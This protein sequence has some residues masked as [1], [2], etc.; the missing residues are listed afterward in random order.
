VKQFGL[1][2]MAD[3]SVNH[4]APDPGAVLAALGLV[5]PSRIT[6]VSGGADATIWRVGYGDADYALRLLRADQAAMARREA[7]AM[8]AAAGGIPVPRVVVEGSWDNRPALL[9]SWMPGRILWDELER[10]PW[11]AWALGVE[12]GRTQAAIH[13]ASVPAALRRH[14]VSWIEW[15][16]PD[17]ALRDRLR[18]SGDGE[19]LLHLD[20]HPANVLV[21]DGRVSAVLDWANARAGDRRADLARTAAIL[22]FAPPAGRPS[23]VATIT[24]RVFIA[25]W[26]HGYRGMAGRVSG[27]APFYAWAAAVMRHDLAPRVGRT[28]LPWLTPALLAEICRWEDRWRA[29]AGLYD[30]PPRPEHRDDDPDPSESRLSVRDA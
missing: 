12:F 1:E 26:R 23:P 22:R 20:Y 28:D 10:G 3:V 17:A 7:V 16:E 8:A 13:A 2:V 18:R 4:T 5:E 11:R 29:A 9:L 24:R 14:P 15:A 6:P 21:E 27:M 19:V 25:G 30:E